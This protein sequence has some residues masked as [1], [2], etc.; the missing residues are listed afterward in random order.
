MDDSPLSIAASITGILTFVAAI[1]GFVYV[2]YTVL[3]NGTDEMFNVF[4]SVT[5][6]LDE[7]QALLARIST[8]QGDGLGPGSG[9]LGRLIKDLYSTELLI[10]AQYQNVFSHRHM[11]LKTSM[12]SMNSI[13][14]TLSQLIAANPGGAWLDMMRKAEELANPPSQPQ[15]TRFWRFFEGLKQVDRVQRDVLSVVPDYFSLP[16]SGLRLILSLGVGPSLMRW[17]K[18]RKQVL[19]KMKNREIVRS[20]I[21]F[22]LIQRAAM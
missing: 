8:I 7:T 17:N 6:T 3:K 14:S 11:D 15:S 1:F 22:Y 12:N 4:E 16:W 10:M 5:A 9:R 20:R 19:E 2:R 13:S 21:M 18:I